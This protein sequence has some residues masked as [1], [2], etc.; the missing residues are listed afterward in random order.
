MKLFTKQIDEKLF[1]QY[2]YGNDLEKQVVVAKIFNP[3][4]KGVWYLLNSDPNDPDYIWAIVD[5]LEVEVGSVSRSELESVKVPPFRLPLERDTSFT[6]LPATEVLK[7]AMSG[8]RYAKGGETDS[9]ENKEMLENQVN[10]ILHHSKE[11]S[12]VVSKAKEVEP[13][14][15][16]KIQRASTDL[17]DVTHYLEGE[18]KEKYA[19]GGMTDEDEDE[20]AYLLSD[21]DG[22]VLEKPLH[23]QK[24]EDVTRFSS[25]PYLGMKFKTYEDAKS[26][27]KK[28]REKGIEAKIEKSKRY[29][30]GG[31]MSN[32]GQF[33]YGRSWTMDRKGYNK[34]EN[35]EIPFGYRKA[36]GGQITDVK[37][38]E[39][40][41]VKIY[42]LGV[43]EPKVSTIESARI[44]DPKY[45]HR[46]VRIELMNGA[47]EAIPL[48]KYDE[49]LSGKKIELNDGEEPYMLQL[50]K[51][52]ASG[53]TMASGG[54]MEKNVLTPK[55]GDDVRGY[56][57]KYGTTIKEIDEEGRRFKIKQSDYWDSQDVWISFDDVVVDE[58]D[59][60][61]W[62]KR[63]MRS[64]G[65]MAKGGRIRYTSKNDK[66][67]SSGQYPYYK[68]F[69]KAI[70]S[71]GWFY[72]STKINE[73]IIYPLDE[74][75]ELYYIHFKLKLKDG[76]Y[77]LRYKTD[78][79]KTAHLI[80]FNFEKSLIYFLSDVDDED[81]RN[82]KFESKGIKADYIV[83]EWDSLNHKM[84][85]G[86]ATFSD[87]VSAIK[88][89]LK[90][91]KVP[92]RLKKDYGKRYNAEEAEMAAKRIAGAMRKK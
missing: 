65:V 45:R 69:P 34:K 6:P 9:S 52:K 8:K 43:K 92:S 67:Y 19:S 42:L 32:G 26:F 2:K 29:A 50:V 48:E 16:T 7:G 54:M 27:E 77:L 58:D 70:G 83:I 38:L 73:G 59:D 14:I 22:N 17:A 40:H 39:G 33:N 72:P 10:T 31:M 62:H 55:K 36:H 47:E 61:T 13:W 25:N 78:K 20:D 46:Y 11:L 1:S 87:K 80:K 89:R 24:A 57:H 23:G 91:T 75:D 90:G 28:L 44:D 49:F 56:N 3:Y 35:Y 21:V 4:G 60:S 76:E 30:S 79:M 18:S 71:F 51:S 5:L 85:K 64:G 68:R 53:G 15:I 41:Y 81:D 63:K 82:P 37:E 12:D 88:S 74:F 84:A 86:G 66:D